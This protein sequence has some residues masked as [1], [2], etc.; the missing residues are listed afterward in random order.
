MS[1]RTKDSPL[2]RSRAVKRRKGGIERGGGASVVVD[3]KISRSLKK[4]VFSVDNLDLIA[5]IGSIG[6]LNS[7]RDLNELRFEIWR[8]CDLLDS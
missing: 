4:M 5:L 7:K 6:F 8:G 3:S 2:E 1:K